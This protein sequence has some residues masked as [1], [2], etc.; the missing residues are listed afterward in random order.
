MIAFKIMSNLTLSQWVEMLFGIGVVLIALVYCS[1]AIN[2]GVE[3]EG[4]SSI[5][6]SAKKTGLNLFLI[7]LYLIGCLPAYNI[8]MNN[9]MNKNEA[10]ISGLYSWASV[11][12]SFVSYMYEN[13]NIPLEQ[14][15]KQFEALT[16]TP[17]KLE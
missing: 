9:E 16:S 15:W 6:K 13:R 2:E 5:R 17:P 4:G 8:K 11:G 1:K 12:Y 14:A 7:F 3:R 10:V